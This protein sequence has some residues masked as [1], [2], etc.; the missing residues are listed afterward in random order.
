MPA[1]PKRLT[2]PAVL[3]ELFVWSNLAF[4]ALDVYLAHRVVAFN[5]WGTYV[6][7]VFSIAAPLLIAL[8]WLIG[9]FTAQRGP[10]KAIAVLVGL[11]AVVVGVA[12][13]VLHL[14]G[15]F[16]APTLKR[17]VY[18]APFAAPLA[19]TGLGLLLIMNRMVPHG[20][21][22]WPQW[23]MLMAL[24]G[25]V[26]NLALAL[27]D[28]AQ[29][30]F[31]DWRTWISVVAAAIGV[32][33][34]AVAMRTRVPRGFLKFVLAVMVLQIVVAVMGF[35][36]HIQADLHGPAKAWLDNFIFGAP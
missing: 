32:G 33:F 35:V 36:L 12:G 7:L 5:H 17:L 16:V 23:V 24:G 26:G 8:A 19:Y 4:L 34:L 2:E 20:H 27:A 3:L 22:D 29:I 11:C 25:W 31:K 28:H 21:R 14:D 10:A 9:G 13:L 6:P 1:L 15:F 30:G 18:A